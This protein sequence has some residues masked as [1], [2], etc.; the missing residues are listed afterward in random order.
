MRAQYAGKL[1]MLDKWLGQVFARLD[2]HNLW[3]TTCVILTT[4]HGHFLGDHQW[5]GKGEAPL[6]HTLTHIPMLVW[7]PQGAHNRSRIAATT[8][9]LDLYATVL[10]MLGIDVPTNE[11]VHS[12]SL[13][14]LLLGKRDQ[15][16][17]CAIYGFSNERVGITAGEWTLLRDHDNEAAC[18]YFYTHQV[19]QVDGTGWRKRA[20]RPF[21]YPEIRAGHFIHGVDMPVWRCPVASPGI[22][23]APK[24]PDLLFHNRSDPEQLKNVAH[25]FPDVVH[26]LESSLR[27]HMTSLV[28]PAEQLQRLAL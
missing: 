14:P 24:R 28:A 7:H 23:S 15:H 21:N 18:P 16:R 8:Q 17:E 20:N 3:D 26:R 4:D 5:M 1:T 11:T 10:E 27:D 6:Y 25:D 9:T 22:L 12:R 13:A 19:E 2:L